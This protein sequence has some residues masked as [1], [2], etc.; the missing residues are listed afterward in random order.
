MS[1][2]KHLAIAAALAGLSG[3]SAATAESLPP[4]VASA[5]AP[6]AGSSALQ[7][8]AMLVIFTPPRS[9]DGYTWRLQPID[10]TVIQ[11]KD[12]QPFGA[13]VDPATE[14]GPAEMQWTF[15]AVAV[16]ETTLAFNYVPTSGAAGFTESFTVPVVVR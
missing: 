16:G 10:T 6:E 9:Q 2:R 13:F 14:G 8:G 15:E 7:P 1:I 12:G 5:A 11:A 4:N 3:A